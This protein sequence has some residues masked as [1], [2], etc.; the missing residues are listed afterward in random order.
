MQ[1]SKIGQ[2]SEQVQRTFAATQSGSIYG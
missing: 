2:S 1:D